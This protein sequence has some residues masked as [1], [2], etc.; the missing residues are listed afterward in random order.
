VTHEQALALL[1]EDLTPS[2]LLNA[3]TGASNLRVRLRDLPGGDFCWAILELVP[4]QERQAIWS[5]TVPFESLPTA[6]AYFRANKALESHLRSKARQAMDFL[7]QLRTR[8]G[9]ELT[10]E[11]ALR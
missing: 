2:T 9:V 7:N 10:V 4:G 11:E 6:I 5:A 1:R 3:V 8:L